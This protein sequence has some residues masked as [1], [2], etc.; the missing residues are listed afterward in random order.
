MSVALVASG[1]G[2]QADDLPLPNIILV[3]ID[4]LRH[5]NLGC[6][7]YERD[8]SPF[9][10]SLAAEGVRFQ[11]AVSTTSWTLPAHAAM[12]TGLYDSTHGLVDN[13]LALGEGHLTL[14]GS[15]HGAAG[16]ACASFDWSEREG[17]SVL[18]LP[19]CPCA[20]AGRRLTMALKSPAI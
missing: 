19:F 12:F 3:S 10:D 20:L 13:D 17:L 4:S 15:V 9:I 6:Y 5:T 14:A 7:G 8:T 11:N 1:C 2:R 18:S 16:A